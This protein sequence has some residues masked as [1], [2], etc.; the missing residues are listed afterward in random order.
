VSVQEVL[1][2]AYDDIAL[3]RGQLELI[4][5]LRCP[6]G[7]GV[8]AYVSITPLQHYVG[9]V[10]YI[11]PASQR[12]SCRGNHGYNARLLVGGDFLLGDHGGR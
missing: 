1:G 7:V 2:Y 11:C 6:C 9:M 3:C 8:L 5:E 4:G 12:N 10:T